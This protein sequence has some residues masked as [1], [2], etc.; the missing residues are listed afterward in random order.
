MALAARSSGPVFWTNIPAKPSLAR[1]C[2][3]KNCPA[4]APPL[5]LHPARVILVLTISRTQVQRARRG[6]GPMERNRRV[7]QTNACLLLP[8]RKT[9][10]ATTVV[11]PQNIFYREGIFFPEMIFMT[12]AVTRLDLA[13][14]PARGEL[15][16][17][18]CSHCDSA[19]LQRG[20]APIPC[21]RNSARRG[22]GD[23]LC[24]QHF[25]AAGAH[26]NSPSNLTFHDI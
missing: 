25:G 6:W 10:T 3:A 16:P 18:A 13:P 7:K 14:T 19:S 1:R 2:K 9:R 15:K 26:R 22:I 20:Q 23:A 4:L 21:R 8:G 11:R 24:P 17:K 12:F 5:W